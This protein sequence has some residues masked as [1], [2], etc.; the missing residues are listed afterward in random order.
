MRCEMSGASR[1]ISA[2]FLVGNCKGGAGC[3]AILLYSHA[4]ING[5]VNAEQRLLSH[6]V[7]TWISG[8]LLRNHDRSAPEIGLRSRGIENG[9]LAVIPARFQT[10]RAYVEAQGCYP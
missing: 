2:F 10:G 6:R 8:H 1:R 7:I 5:P 9:D 4:H 3:V